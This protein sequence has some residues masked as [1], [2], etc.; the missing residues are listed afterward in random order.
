MFIDVTTYSCSAYSLHMCGWDSLSSVSSVLSA[1]VQ[2]PWH[3]EC[4]SSLSSF[5]NVVEEGHQESEHGVTVPKHFDNKILTYQDRF[6]EL[7]DSSAQW[8][9][10][11]MAIVASWEKFCSDLDELSEWLQSQNM[12]LE[13]LQVVE[14]FANEFS[15]HQ[16]RLSVSGLCY[17]R[18]WLGC[19]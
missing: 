14:E 9:A 17:L 12:E 11:I 15:S 16:A 19:R 8:K 5:R 13:S 2:V 18:M 6:S 1:C 10:K 3:N 7:A 4:R